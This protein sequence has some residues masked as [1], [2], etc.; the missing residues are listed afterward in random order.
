MTLRT[1]AP[2]LIRRRRRTS[3]G[4]SGPTYSSE[5]EALIDQGVLNAYNIPAESVL[6]AQNTF[7]E[8]LKS[9]GIYSIFDCLYI[10]RGSLSDFSRMNVIDPTEE[11]IN[12]GGTFNAASGWILDGVS[13]YLTIGIT[14][15]NHQSESASTIG[16]FSQNGAT[17]ADF[18]S[19]S[20]SPAKMQIRFNSAG[21]LRYGDNTTIVLDGALSQWNGSD[22]MYFIA[23]NSTT[24]GYMSFNEFDQTFTEADTSNWST[25]YIDHIG[26]RSATFDPGIMQFYAIG[27]LLT[28]AQK[29]TIRTLWSNY[30]ASL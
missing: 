16:F 9:N 24:T 25:D 14:P 23:R 1:S 12:S 6:I 29:N 17:L 2:Y 8:G 15:N 22:G 18:A 28:I 19:S 10:S 30:V 5:M 21:L 26:R 20:M 27:G 4:G 11:T 7:I 3:G 13:A